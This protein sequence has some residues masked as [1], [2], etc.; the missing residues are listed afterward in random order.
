[1]NEYIIKALNEMD[2]CLDDKSNKYKNSNGQNIPRV[3]EIISNMIHSDSLMYWANH[4][5]FKGIRY[6]DALNNASRIGTAAHAAIENF[7][8]NKLECDNVPFLGFMTWYNIITVDKK[9]QLEVIYVEHTITCQWFGGTL[10]ALFRINGKVYLIDFKTSNHVTFKYFIQLAAYR[11]ML[12]ESE[13]IDVDGVIVL[14]LDKFDPGFNEYLLSF[15]IP[16][17]AIFMNNCET[18]FLSLVYSYYN[19]KN[20]EGEY[21]AIF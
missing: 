16:D 7:L 1:M 10:D 21:K 17:H 5:G 6:S 3:T 8:N 19:I 12:R 14:Q 2:I 13:G 18:T 11:Y 4:I 9:L 15:D 20:I